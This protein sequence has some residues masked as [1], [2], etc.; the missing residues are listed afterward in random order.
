M[1][2]DT[3]MAI[4]ALVTAHLLG[5]FA[6]QNTAQ[7]HRKR[8]WIVL[9]GHAGTVAALSYLLVARWDNWIV[10]GVVFLSHAAID[11]AKARVQSDRHLRTF[12]LDQLAHLAVI[13]TVGISLEALSAPS[14]FGLSPA[15]YLRALILVSGLVFVVWTSGVIIGF[16][17]EPYRQQM[18]Q[19][20]DSG[21]NATGLAGA[22]RLIGQLERLLI[23]VLFLS[24]N[25]GAIG[26]LIGKRPS[27]SLSAR[28]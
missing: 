15:L 19:A 11:A 26:F 23:F 12:T 27:T 17:V 16:L 21:A 14:Y 6:L 25:P 5:D 2:P 4:A 8:E 13:I 10:P 20:E 28:S 24:G 1:S 22:G 7:V 9:A 18:A 3:V